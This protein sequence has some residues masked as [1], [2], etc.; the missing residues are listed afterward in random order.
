[1][2]HAAALDEVEGISLTGLCDILESRRDQAARALDVPGYADAGELI[3]V[4]HPDIVV[5]AT[6]PDVRAG[7]IV[8]IA[9][10]E[11]VRAIVVEKPLALSMSE[12]EA[13][14]AVADRAGVRLTVG[15]QLRFAPH[16]IALQD[17]IENGE[18]GTIEFIRALSYGD[19]LDQGPHLV[20]AARALTGGRRVLWSMSQQG[21]ML[22]RE[23]QEG[24]RDERLAEIPAWSTHHLAL[25]GGIRCTLETGPL[26]QRSD[27]FG[28]GEEID[29]YLDK[30]LTVVGSRGIAQFVAGGDYRILSEND[31]D[32]RTHPGGIAAYISAT[33]QLH[34]DVRDSLLRGIPS[35]ADAADALHSL[36]G[37]LACVQSVARGDAVSLPLGDEEE[38]STLPRALEGPEVSVI[39]PLPDH[40]GYAAKAVS[41]WSQGQTFDRD[42]YEVIVV[43]DGAEPEL[44][45]TVESL[46]GSADRLIREEGVSEVELYDRASRAASGRLLVFTEP[47]CIAEPAFIEEMLVHLA[48]T[49]DQGACARTVAICPN[50]LARMEQVLYDESFSVFAQPG[51][52]CKVILRAFAIERSTYLEAGGFEVQYGRFAEFALAARLHATGKRI[53][54]APGVAVEHVYTTNFSQLVPP[55]DDFLAGELRYRLDHPVPYCERYFGVPEEWA[56]RGE[57]SRDGARAAWGVAARALLRPSSWRAGTAGS[58]LATAVRLVPAALLGARAARAH[59]GL[60]LAV[61]R[62]RCQLWRLNERRMLRAYRDASHWMSRR[63]RLRFLGELAPHAPELDGKPSFALAEVPDQRLFGFHRAERVDGTTFRWSRAVACAEVPVGPGEYRVEIDTGGLRDPRSLGVQVFFNGRRIPASRLD[64]DSTRISFRLTPS[65]FSAGAAQRLGLVAA[66]FRPARVAASDDERELALPISSVDFKPLREGGR[67]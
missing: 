66:P 15:H 48:R 63:A 42:R 27:R 47:H 55:I 26:H 22:T 2:E 21:P 53:G 6:P 61:A 59:A 16:F 33:R 3:D 31:T 12:A 11:S 56:A 39:L 28:Q 4:T 52:W 18:L 60:R 44:D 17:A 7:L 23:L 1:M 29:D 62:L 43:S 32:W 41:S 24:A 57:L 20:D 64:L 58:L 36:E 30:R 49:G 37:L 50:A 5:V 65:E 13:I 46:L 9:E 51:H 8:P 34:E 35:R 38:R 25:E 67:H 10:S 54:Y 45:Q 19:L 40:R 14:V